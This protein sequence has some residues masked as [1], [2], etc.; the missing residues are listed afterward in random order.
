MAHSEHIGVRWGQAEQ[1]QSPIFSARVL[2]TL[3]LHGESAVEPELFV[4]WDASEW[5][6]GHARNQVECFDDCEYRK[7][8]R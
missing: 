3:Y 1:R 8:Q 4:A 7:E 2:N 5:G 6:T